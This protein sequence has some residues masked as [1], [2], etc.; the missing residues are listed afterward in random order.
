MMRVKLRFKKVEDSPMKS[1]KIE[2]DGTTCITFTNVKTIE[3]EEVEN[4]K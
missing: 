2:R 3:A 4:Q 1:W